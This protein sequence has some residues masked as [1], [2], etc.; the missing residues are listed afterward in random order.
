MIKLRAEHDRDNKHVACFKT[1]KNQSYK[2]LTN[3]E[4]LAQR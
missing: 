3:Y 1:I 4:E 2:Y